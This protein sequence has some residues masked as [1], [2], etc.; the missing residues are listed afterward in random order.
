MRQSLANFLAARLDA[1]HEVREEQGVDESHPVDVKV[2]R[3][4]SNRLAII[5]I[6]WLG[7]SRDRNH[8]TVRY[9]DS[10]AL[11]GAKQL[12]DYLDM[13]RASAPNQVTRGYLV[14]IDA[15]RR[16]LAET[17]TSISRTEGMHY[18]DIEIEYAVHH[19]QLRDDFEKP[20]RMFAEPVCRD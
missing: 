17:T 2:T 5:E 4:F 9:R 1:S 18:R 12:A 19:D 13:N 16:G 10:R 3:L 11:E 20:L 6:K 14:V 15:R 8:I 7:D